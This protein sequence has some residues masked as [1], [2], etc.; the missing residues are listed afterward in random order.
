MPIKHQLLVWHLKTF[1]ILWVCNISIELQRI[2]GRTVHMNPAFHKISKEKN[3]PTCLLF[4][5]FHKQIKTEMSL[6]RNLI[7]VHNNV[8]MLNTSSC[9]DYLFKGPLVIKTLLLPPKNAINKYSI[10]TH[11]TSDLPRMRDSNN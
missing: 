1:L 10:I 11:S 5:I 9:I 3:P 2:H 8:L 7:N 6:N 4:W